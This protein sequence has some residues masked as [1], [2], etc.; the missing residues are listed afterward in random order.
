[1]DEQE[2][3]VTKENCSLDK[4]TVDAWHQFLKRLGQQLGKETVD[5]WVATLHIKKAGYRRLTLEA[6]DSF[7]ALWFEEHVRP[8]I[9]ACVDP[10]GASIRVTLQTGSS[11]AKRTGK[12]KKGSDQFKLHFRDLDPTQTFETFHVQ[13]EN[14]LVIKLLDEMCSH[15]RATKIKDLSSLAAPDSV[16]APPN[17][18]Y[19]YGPTGSGKTHLLT[20]SALRL[21]KAG[22]TVAIAR[23]ELFTEHV[24]RAIRA[25]EM[26]KF[27]QFWRNCDV[28]MLDDVHLLARKSTTQEEFFHT[29]NTLHV[30]GKQI[31]LAANCQPGQLQFIEPRL[32]SRFEWGLVLPLHSPPKKQFIHLLEQKASLLKFPLSPA[33]IQEISLLFSSSFT[34]AVRALETL[35]LR[36]R[37]STSTTKKLNSGVLKDLLADLIAQE[38]FSALTPD[39]ILSI[40]AESYGITRQDLLLRSQNREF[41]LPR[42]VAMYLVRKH[43][44]LPYMKIGDLFQKN[45]S[46][47]MSSVRH[48][49][50]MISDTSTDVGSSIASI[51]INLSE[52]HA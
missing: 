2:K 20:S 28:L 40:T 50:K 17:P 43:L 30:A 1:M 5:R 10:M 21:Q 35:I 31:L 48:V 18:I 47:V 51:E 19:V 45:H 9:G 13:Q 26:A 41:V 23:A 49:E 27:R 42:Q 44:K 52:I 36:L 4:T 3:D 15:L 16:Q 39:K 7:Q 6:K 33:I 32:V 34:S 25:G 46:T 12:P 14:L 8:K 22:L 38:K 24:V 37:L 29:F 11:V